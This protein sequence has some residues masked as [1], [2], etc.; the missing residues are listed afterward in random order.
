MVLT[1]PPF[2]LPRA[3]FPWLPFEDARALGIYIWTA[4]CNACLPSPRYPA[5]NTCRPGGEQK[6][7]IS[8]ESFC[9][10]SFFFVL[11]VSNLSPSLSTEEVLGTFPKPSQNIWAEKMTNEDIQSELS[12]GSPGW[13]FSAHIILTQS[14]RCSSCHQPEG[15][16]MDRRRDRCYQPSAEPRARW[17]EQPWHL[18][19]A[20][21]ALPP[22]PPNIPLFC[23]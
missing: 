23:T 2:M 17:W 16:A 13:H 6:L 9:S 21:D 12:L 15:I 4:T 3:T 14:K 5:F 20:G 7:L 10:F 22:C 8:K 1:L 11:R 19:S 18:R